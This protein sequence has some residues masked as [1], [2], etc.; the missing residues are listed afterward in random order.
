[1]G[2]FVDL[3]GKRFGRLVVVSRAKDHISKSGRSVVVF[4]C[5]CDCGNE[6]DV[7][8]TALTRGFTKSCGCLKS[9]VVKKRMMK[10]DDVSRKLRIVH[11]NIIER[12]Y[13]KKNKR[14]RRYG[15]RGIVVC[16]EW[17][18][19]GG[20]ERF[21]EWARENGYEIGLTIDRIDNDGPYSPNN[22]RWVTAKEQCN[23]RSTNTFLTVDGTTK[24]IA[25]WLDFL[26]IKSTRL[27]YYG[28]EAKVDYVRKKLKEKE[29]KN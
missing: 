26:G 24:T 16:E 9:E 23:N 27:Y 17:L 4:R 21:I 6:C 1:M 29:Y 25:Q 5:R 11:R 2:K 28:E 8:G 18:A 13:D 7:M 10:R 12:C 3:T 22:C 20:Q 15:G 19:D 14:Y